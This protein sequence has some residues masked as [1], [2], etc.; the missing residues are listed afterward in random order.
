MGGG[1]DGGP[2]GGGF[3]LGGESTVNSARA[4]C[5]PLESLARTWYTPI[6]MPFL[7][8]SWS[9]SIVKLKVPLWSTCGS[10]FAVPKPTS[11]TDTRVDGTNPLP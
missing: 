2:P 7:K 4:D 11:A 1:P 5:L 10:N 6:G 8:K 9:W 3:A